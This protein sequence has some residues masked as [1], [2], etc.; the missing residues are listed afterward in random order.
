[1]NQFRQWSPGGRIPPREDIPEEYTWDLSAIYRSDE[2]W[3]ESF[4]SADAQLR[5][6]GTYEGRLF[7]TPRALL[8][9]LRLEEKASERIGKLYAYSTMKSHE[10]TSRPLYQGM[11]DRAAMLFSSFAAA[12]SFFHPEVLAAGEEMIRECMGQLPELALYRHYFD[13]ILRTREHVLSRTEEELLARSAEVARTAESAFSLLTNADMTFPLIT[14]ERGEEVELSEERYY[15]LSRSRDRRVRRE[16]YEGLLGTY[17][18]YRNSIGA[19]YSGSVRGDAF[20]AKARRYKSSLAASLDADNIPVDVYDNVIDT[21]NDS[22]DALHDYMTLRKGALSLVDLRMYDLNVPLA[23]EPDAPIP[24]QDATEMVIEA[25][26]PLGAEYVDLLR[27]GFRSRWIDVY[28]NQGKRKG[29]YSWGCYGAHPY[30]LLNYGGTLR[31]VFTIAHEMGHSLHTW[32]SHKNQPQI[33]ADYTI[34]LAEVASTVNETL[35]LERLLD[36]ASRAEKI[37]LLN[38]YLDQVRT[39]VYRQAMFAEFERDMHAASERGEALTADFLSKAWKEL[40]TRYHGPDMSPDDFI[41]VEWARIPHFYSAF[42]VYK[43]VTGFAAASML[44]RRLREGTEGERERYLRFLSR[45]SSAYSLDILKEAGVD[46]A[47]P[48]PLKE[49]VASFREKTTMLAGL[50]GL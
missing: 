41:E 4:R 29:G 10:D 14:D 15:V 9:Y 43:Y 18:K 33:Y 27:E 22:L 50:L 5:E 45:G 46:M 17:R 19:L 16:A 24:Y 28:E 34:F 40:N 49:A 37:Y 12:R 47:A 44:A 8:D 23:D 20:Y 13:D 25:L 7:K 39:T 38:H 26:A 21:V 1:M 32:Y 48:E 3:E 11:S 31:D 6:L 30:V 42:Y 2:E 36:K 35:L